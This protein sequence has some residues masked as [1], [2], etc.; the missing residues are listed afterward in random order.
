MSILCFLISLCSWV[1]FLLSTYKQALSYHG[2]CCDQVRNI[3]ARVYVLSCPLSDKERVRQMGSANRFNSNFCRWC[4]CVRRVCI[5]QS[6]LKNESDSSRDSRAIVFS[7]FQSFDM[8][9]Y[10]VMWFWTLEMV[11]QLSQIPFLGRTSGFTCI[12]RKNLC[13]RT[14][15]S[16]SLILSM[17]TVYGND[18]WWGLN[19]PNTLH[20]GL[21]VSLFAD[22]NEIDE[23]TFIQNDSGCQSN[24]YCGG[25]NVTR[26][27][28]TTVRRQQ[29]MHEKSCW[30]C[31]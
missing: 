31:A 14:I 15:A 5:Q 21:V 25:I 22:D 18:D 26:C 13:G 6:H 4:V 20:L 2:V 3:D 10:G 1:N 28:Y 9:R 16:T 7:R 19:L 24:V 8:I 23:H 27:V 30:N 17:K 12:L 11:H 29:L